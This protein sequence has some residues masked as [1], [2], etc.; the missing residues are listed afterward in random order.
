MK[1]KSLS[2]DVGQLGTSDD[3]HR[4]K[5]LPKQTLDVNDVEQLAKQ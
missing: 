5:R 4:I 1:L 3:K 2:R